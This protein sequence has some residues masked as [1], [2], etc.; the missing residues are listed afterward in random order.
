M[1]AI[2]NRNSAEALVLTIPPISFHASTREVTAEAV[3]ATPADG[4]SAIVVLMASTSRPA[5]CSLLIPE[6]NHQ[7]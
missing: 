6:W 7:E 5:P 2:A 3:N 1:K 4:H